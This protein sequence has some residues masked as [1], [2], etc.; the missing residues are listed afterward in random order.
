M[1]DDSPAP[2]QTDGLERHA[3]AVLSYFMGD[4]ARQAKI[5]AALPEALDHRRFPAARNSGD[6][7]VLDHGGG[8]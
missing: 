7:Q 6:E 1:R 8:L 2:S 4:K 3:L 5:A